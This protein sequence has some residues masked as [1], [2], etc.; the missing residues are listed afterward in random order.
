V[1]CCALFLLFGFA[2]PLVAP[3]L[4]VAVAMLVA[5]G[6]VRAARGAAQ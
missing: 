2:E 4:F 5:D 3:A 6:L 1:L